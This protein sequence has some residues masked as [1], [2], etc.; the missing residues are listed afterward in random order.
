MEPS[1][2]LLSKWLI[3]IPLAMP[4]AFASAQAQQIQAADDGTGTTVNINGN[5]FE[6]GGGILSGDGAN[7]FHSFEQ[8]G[9]EAD[10]IAN[11]ISNPQIGNIFSRVV[12]GN[13]SLIDGLIQVTGGNPNLFLI[14]PA[15]IIFGSNA[16]LNL[17]A[18]FTA[19]TATGIGFSGD[20]WFNV[21]G[22]NDYQN[23]IGVPTKF[24][25]D[26]A[27]PGNIVNAGNL[28]VRAG[29]NLTL[30]GGSVV[31]TGQLRTETGNLV[32]A[33]VPGENL[34]R[35]S[36]PG[37]LL[38]LEIE[39]RI[40]D[41]QLP[42]ISPLDLPTLLTGAAGIVETG[43]SV[44]P[45][46]VVQLT[47][48]EAQIPTEANTTIVSGTLD[49]STTA[50]GLPGGQI[51]ILGDRIGVFDANINASG[52]NGGT[53]LIGGSAQG[54][55][56]L[57]KALRTFISG[58][59]VINADARENGNGGQVV[60]WADQATGFYGNVSARGSGD[61]QNPS[62]PS[63]PEE[64]PGNAGLV[65]IGSQGDL[66][67]QGTVEL[68]SEAVNTGRLLLAAD[69]ITVVN[70]EGITDQA[71]TTSGSQILTSDNQL[72]SRV[73]ETALEALS[74]NAEIILRATDDI[75]INDLADG[76]LTFAP[77]FGE[78]IELKADADG[79][80]SGSF[81]MDRQNTIS[82][83]SR[84]FLIEGANI[85]VGS[86][87]TGSR[88]T[89]QDSGSVSLNATNGNIR[90]ENLRS[91]S[92]STNGGSINL[93][94]SNGNIRVN[95]LDSSSNSNLV[96]QSSNGG[97]ITLNAPRGEIN[98]EEVTS[99]SNQ[100]AG[101]ID[102]N[103]DISLNDR[104]TTITT[105]GGL[106]SGN[107]T[108]NN[109]L[110]GSTNK[111]SELNLNSGNGTITL[112][113]IG[114]SEPLSNLNINGT[115]II[116]LSGAY[117]LPDNY[118]FNNPLVLISDANI[119]SK[120]NLTFNNSLTAD[121]HNLTLTANEID[122]NNSVSGYG[123]IHL[124]PFTTSQAIAIG[125][126]ENSNPNVLELTNPEIGLLNNRFSLITI[127]HARG[128][129]EITLAG[130]TVWRDP[131][132][133]QSPLGAGSID[134]TDHNIIGHSNA[135]ITLVANQDIATGN[136]T[137]PG[138]EVNLIS[139]NGII[140]TTVGTIDTGDIGDGG[141]IT[142]DAADGIITRE[143]NSSSEAGN[144]GNI[145]FNGNNSVIATRQL[146]SS[147]SING[148][149]VQ[150]N[151]AFN[152]S[153][154]EIDSSG[155]LGKDGLVSF[156]YS[157]QLKYTWL[158]TLQN[159]NNSIDV[160]T[161]DFLLARS[162]FVSESIVRNLFDIGSD[163]TI[164]SL[165]NRSI[166]VQRANNA[167]NSP[168]RGDVAD[169]NLTLTEDQS[170]LFTN[171]DGD[172][173]IVGIESASSTEPTPE[174]SA[175]P[176]G[177]S[178]S[179][180]TSRQPTEVSLIELTPEPSAQPVDNSNSDLTSRQP[181][182]VSLIEPTP[183]PS[184]QPVSNSNSDLTS[185][186]RIKPPANF[187]IDFTNTDWLISPELLS[188][189]NDTF[190][191]IETTD[192]SFSYD[193]Q[194]YLGLE[195]VPGT[196]LIQASQILQNVEDATGIK[197]AVIY[198]LFVPTATT[199]T[200]S[201]YLNGEDLGSPIPSLLRS[202]T[203]QPS[204]RLELIIVTSEGKPIRQSLSVTR[205]EVISTAKKFRSAVT[206]RRNQTGYLAPAQQMYE[207]LVAPVEK[208]LQRLGIQ[209]LAYIMD[210]GLRSVPLAALHD[211]NQFLVER[212]SVSLMPSL[213]LTDT[214]PTNIKNAQVLAMGASRFSNK[215][216]LPSVPVELDNIIS[217]WSGK[218]FL[219]QDFT[220]DNL[221][222]QRAINPFGI[223]HL[224]THA[225]FQ[226]GEP[227]KSYIQLDDVKLPPEKLG[228]LGWTKPPVELLVLSAC[229]T[230]VGDAE[231]ELGFAGLAVQ[232]G[233]KS[234]LAS[235]WYVSDQG[236]LGLMSE[237]YQNLQQAPTKAE[238]LRQT[239]IAMLQGKVRIEA[240]KLFTSQENFPFPSDL[241]G[242]GN[243][244][245]SHP[246]YWSAFAL[247][248]NPW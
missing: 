51:N 3:L 70:G 180:L 179:D 173:R 136:I 182:E 134:T 19:T 151:E 104:N 53:V 17:P 32:I 131:T 129:G 148:G 77:G 72:V 75:T 207:W 191:V 74:S 214:R 137:N 199:P 98:F 73:A 160:N 87:D 95:S 150:I 44:S 65:E 45:N 245:F 176:V 233:V 127:G 40:V 4:I 221:K 177:N 143:I 61:I 36:Q 114:N 57:P 10:Q 144:G 54:N 228:S 183:E 33:A 229:R 186:Q 193:F 220:L 43:L 203:A 78:G 185:E 156:S 62:L 103:G 184:A 86:L 48:T 106:V 89:L 37:H 76:E 81:A 154:E 123:E 200:S 158:N 230:A 8:L 18:A 42:T 163:A 91:A 109:N 67:F 227:D 211:G 138:R 240:G 24:A 212:Y 69:E 238:A 164:P 71:E 210:T 108:F 50:V 16:Q 90:A 22:E 100:N 187:S 162:R 159:N 205:A 30:L 116:R 130:E 56:S 244:V 224:A 161:L 112:N 141:A 171:T 209:N 13:P 181:T 84:D 170:Y 29:E 226:P 190:Q 1:S 20:S 166:P 111:A 6:I 39:P 26:W 241:P 178:S 101:N 41:E 83:Q 23:L 197:P 27:E 219:N 147:G 198:A 82:A 204:D 124:Q 248:G 120:E 31:N 118:T 97:A 122:F 55:N 140:D 113:G 168:N 243:R 121:R 94:T 7:L 66:V 49:T 217:I 216:S 222:S 63:M 218:Y 132:V 174:P 235:L 59:S 223:I 60:V 146:D 247:V 99:S 93:T 35:I 2:N 115:G 15:G 88:D 192:K 14:N 142:L 80:G 38:S 225:Q 215:I 11:F 165:V 175:Q 167:D 46:G 149:D 239:Q 145:T 231:A 139:N 189:Q 25:F 208:E 201:D 213:S 125:G 237:F 105:I 52:S 110:N 21:F 155:F 128:S 234:A 246:Y 236:T 117:F 126:N 79:N 5:Q 96:N 47:G 102:I 64:T 188:S 133:W 34:V 172:V 195:E 202:Q 157:D 92:L 9:L 119:N 206:D 85:R 194:K 12:G 135:T 169:L 242:Q 232:A 196:T 28:V 68:S 107:I 153:A 152:F 58:S